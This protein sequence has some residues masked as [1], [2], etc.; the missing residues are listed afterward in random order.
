M[1]RTS[2]NGAGKPEGG[3]TRICSYCNRIHPRG[4][5]QKEKARRK[6]WVS[7]N[8]YAISLRRKERPDTQ[9]GTSTSAQ[10]VRA[11]KCQRCKARNTE[12]RLFRIRRG[13]MGKRLRGSS[14]RRLMSA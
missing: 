4:K 1:P 2:W 3:K 9:T 5:R 8:D 10:V 6:G 14:L 7:C 11:A 12:R 13:V